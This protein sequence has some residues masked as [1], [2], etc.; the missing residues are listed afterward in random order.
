MSDYPKH[1]RVRKPLFL[2]DP[3]YSL[4]LDK[5]YTADAEVG[6]GEPPMMYATGAMDINISIFISLL[7]FVSVLN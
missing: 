7:T 6:I 3:M 1:S 5:Y 4:D 2:L